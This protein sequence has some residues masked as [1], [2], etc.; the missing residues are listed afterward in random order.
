MI[1]AAVQF[2]DVVLWAHITALVIAFGPTYAYGVFFAVAAK[3]GPAALIPVARA[4]QTWDRI[5]GT[6]GGLVILAS[7]LYLVSDSPVFELSTFFVSWGIV[8]I[9]VILGLTHAFFL[10]R[11]SKVQALLEN[12]QDAEA[13]AVGNQ[14]GRAGAA[15]GVVVILTIYV[16]TVKPFL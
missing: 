12:G 11:S 3:S 7:G 5:A 6:I 4:V 14:I 9:I 2:Y 10:P 1:A 16:M 8:A 15:L 13:R